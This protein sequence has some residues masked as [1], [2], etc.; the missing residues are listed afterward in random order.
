MAWVGLS[1]LPWLHAGLLSASAAEEEKIEGPHWTVSFALGS[2]GAET[3]KVEVPK[4]IESARGAL[5]KLAEQSKFRR[6]TLV[7]T[8]LLP[9]DAPEP[10]QVAF[11]RELAFT[12]QLETKKGRDFLQAAWLRREAGPEGKFKQLGGKVQRPFQPSKSL[13]LMGPRVK[14]GVALAVLRLDLKTEN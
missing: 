4:E 6:F 14:E 8:K 12:F 3:E 11:D 9:K 2:E 10:V 7:K 5:E 1:L 13:V